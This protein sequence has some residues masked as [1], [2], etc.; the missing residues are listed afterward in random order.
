VISKF[1]FPAVTFLLILLWIYA[2][3]SKLIDFHHFEAEM[4]NQA[5]PPIVQ[6][7]LIYGL[8]PVELIVAGLLI[9]DKTYVAG[10][11]ASLILLTI[12]TGY[13]TLTI[14]HFFSYVPC[15]C[16]G[17]LEKMSWTTHLV[18]NLFFIFLTLTNLYIKLKERRM[19]T[20]RG[21]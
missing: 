15:S 17:I 5:I 2:S 4:H 9:G 20:L 14:L 3:I 13:I 8:P 12:F 18:F 1:L 10:L 19:V 21:T 11:L 7:F 16:G 6:A